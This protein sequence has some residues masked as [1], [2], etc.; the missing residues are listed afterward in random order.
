LSYRNTFSLLLIF[1]NDVKGISPEKAGFNDLSSENIICFLEWL[2]T[3]RGN[4]VAT[5]N[6][7]LA[8]IH[9]FAKYSM[10]T[11]PDLI[12]GCQR[13]LSVEY[14]KASKTVIHY[15]S[16]EQMEKLLKQPNLSTP[17]GR[18][19][20]ALLSL[21][22]DSGARVQELIDLN[23]RDI[24]INLPATVTLTGKGRKIRQV[25]LMKGTAILVD[26]YMEE[27]QLYKKRI[28]R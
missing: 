22:Y 21:L 16:E 1:L 2:E 6:Q 26:R 12:Y 17:Q 19:D 3:W 5:R 20:A 13:I 14:K 28:Q 11:R 27:N 18:R 24:R 10:F 9:A 8:A 15:L 7:R 25:P 4:S 23:V